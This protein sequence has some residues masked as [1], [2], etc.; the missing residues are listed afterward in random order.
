MIDFNLHLSQMNKLEARVASKNSLRRNVEED[1]K[2]TT[3]KGIYLPSISAIALL[4][5]S[6][7]YFV[8]YM[9]MCRIKYRMI[10]YRYHMSVTYSIIKILRPEA[11]GAAWLKESKESTCLSD[12]ENHNKYKYDSKMSTTDVHLADQLYSA[13]LFAC[14]KIKCYS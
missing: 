11:Q 4:I 5:H 2:A 6:S 3:Q 8:D 7:V 1:L 13:S 10:K 9:I 12:L 14:M